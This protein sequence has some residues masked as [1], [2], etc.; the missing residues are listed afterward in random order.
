MMCTPFGQIHSTWY[1]VEG[2]Q[3]FS[4]F[5]HTGKFVFR[6]ASISPNLEGF[7]TLP[8]EVA[9][10]GH[11]CASNK[12]DPSCLPPTGQMFPV[13]SNDS[14]GSSNKYG[15]HAPGDEAGGVGAL[16]GFPL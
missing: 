15:V 11:A 3:D 12:I 2:V 13:L 14:P 1:H 9:L 8:R 7:R 4:D 16:A 10:R 5:I 6:S